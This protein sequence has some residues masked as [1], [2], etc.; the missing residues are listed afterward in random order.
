MIWTEEEELYLQSIQDSCEKLSAVYLAG[1]KRLHRIQA[2]IK[3]P[4]IIIGSFTGITSF[5]AETFPKY[6]QK[7]VSVGV[8]VVTIGI[9]ILNTIESYFK[10]SENCNAAINTT[11]ALQQLREDINKEL[12]LPTNDRQAPGLTFLRDIYTR[13]QQILSQAPMLDDGSISYINA[14]AAPRLNSIIRKNIVSYEDTP[15]RSGDSDTSSIKSFFNRQKKRTSRDTQRIDARSDARSDALNTST[16]ETPKDLPGGVDDNPS[17][18]SIASDVKGITTSHAEPVSNIIQEALQITAPIK[19][20]LNKSLINSMVA[21]TLLNKE[22]V[23]P[24][25]PP[26]IK[27]DITIDG[28]ARKQKKTDLQSFPLPSLGADSVEEKS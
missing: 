20:H 22:T 2:K 8:G 19:E 6:A 13:Y 21:S 28:K 23:N 11:N 1:Y 14:L 7:W 26:E 9:A 24:R 18:S 10:I 5:G 15:N 4:V 16:H 25:Q 12:S 27:V 17:Q 3:I